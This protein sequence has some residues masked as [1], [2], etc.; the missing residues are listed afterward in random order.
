MT[1]L[2]RHSTPPLF[3]QRLIGES[4][5]SLYVPVSY[6]KNV[7]NIEEG[8]EMCMT[9]WR[10]FSSKRI[11]P[12]ASKCQEAPGRGPLISLCPAFLNS[13]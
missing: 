2:Y 12:G 3:I 13:S 5:I 11:S 7:Q 1:A 8:K 10:I 4:V 6:E 9:L